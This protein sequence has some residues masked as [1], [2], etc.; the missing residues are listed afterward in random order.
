MKGRPRQ[1]KRREIITTSV[2]A[3][4]MEDYREICDRE[5]IEYNGPIKKFLADFVQKKK[6]QNNPQSTLDQKGPATPSVYSNVDQKRVWFEYHKK[7]KELLSDLA[8]GID[9]YSHLLKEY[10]VR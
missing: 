8:W 9:E 3:D 4:I 5:R 7:D 1:Y 2:D 6:E 10:G